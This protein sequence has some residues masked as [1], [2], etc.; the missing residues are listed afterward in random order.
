M[1]PLDKFADEELERRSRRGYILG[2]EVPKG[3]QSFSEF[4]KDDLMQ[5]LDFITI[6]EA[7]DAYQR[8][9]DAN[10]VQPG[11]AKVKCN[12][13]KNDATFIIHKIAACTEHRSRLEKFPKEQPHGKA[14]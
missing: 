9:D 4:I 3:Y 5:G 8:K 10:R 6:N 1:D 14:R 13:C 11:A 12:F 2:R 7:W